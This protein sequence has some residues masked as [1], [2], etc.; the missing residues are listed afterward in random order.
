MSYDEHLAERVRML[1]P[2]TK[3]AEK[4]MMGGLTFMVDEKMSFGMLGD[5]LMVNAASR[6]R[7]TKNHCVSNG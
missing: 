5:E 2:R 6:I 7:D 4:K 3:V 1:L